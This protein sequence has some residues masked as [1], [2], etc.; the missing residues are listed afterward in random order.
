MWLW[1]DTGSM[2]SADLAAL[3]QQSPFVKGMVDAARAWVFFGGVG[4]DGIVV[5]F[6]VVRTPGLS[7]DDYNGLADVAG[8]VFARMLDGLSLEQR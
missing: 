5:I 8:P 6:Y 3:P 4:Q 2:S 1:I 7:D